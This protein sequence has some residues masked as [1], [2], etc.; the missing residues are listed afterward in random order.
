M[1]DHW[2]LFVGI[3]EV[4]FDH[5][6]DGTESIGGAPLNVNVHAHQ[7]AAA[8][9][10]GE[11]IVVSRVGEDSAGA[12]LLDSPRGCGMAVDCTGFDPEHAT[13]C[14]TV[15]LANSEPAY[16]IA[17][18]PAWDYLVGIPSPIKLAAVCDA[19]CFGSLAQRTI[20]SRCTIQYF[21]AAAASAIS[22]FDVN[23]PVNPVTGQKY[24]DPQVLETGCDLAHIIKPNCSE[25]IALSH[26]LE[27]AP[28]GDV[29][30]RRIRF[31]AGALLARFP[32]RAIVTRGQLGTVLFTRENEV[33]APVPTGPVEVRPVGAGDACSAEFLVAL[34]LG[35]DDRN[36]VD[37][38]NRMWARL[39]SHVSALHRC[40]GR[41]SI[42]SVRNYA[43]SIHSD[44]CRCGVVGE[45][46]GLRRNLST[47]VSF[48]A[49]DK[50]D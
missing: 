16:H 8:I 11:G 28:P 34:M 33:T 44:R 45:R 50:L 46:R 10:G 31:L 6:E 32:A 27:I 37:L 21:L 18:D 4:P 24:F 47:P 41:F 48:L 1:P 38:A 5:F 25:P 19:V 29:N 22:V 17:P 9:G 23:R 12:R 26:L 7:L 2:V 14:V 13:G 43:S 36:A 3:A 35:W 30:E 20:F 40:P 42:T 49:E 15:S 39:A